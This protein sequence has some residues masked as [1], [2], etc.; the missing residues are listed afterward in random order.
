LLLL[1]SYRRRSPA[2]GKSGTIAYISI[3]LRSPQAPQFAFGNVSRYLPDVSNPTAPNI[4]AA[5]EKVMQI[6]ERLRLTFRAEL[7]NAFNHVVFARPTTSIASA[8]FG[9]I[10][11]SQTNT[12]RQY[13]SAC[14]PD[15][16]TGEP[17]CAN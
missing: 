5:I 11:L 2:V 15:S 10:I 16:E 7:F 6:R 9:R 14:V 13:S 1:R 3:S 8:T 17:Q 12:S 4:D